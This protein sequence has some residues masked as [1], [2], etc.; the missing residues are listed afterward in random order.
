LAASGSGNISFSATNATSGAI[1]GIITVTPNDNGDSKQFTIT[2]NPQ[3][4]PAVEI[5][6]NPGFN[7]CESVGSITFTA[8][9]TNEGASP[10]YEWKVDG[11]SV[12]T[13]A[14]EN[15]TLNNLNL[16]RKSKISCTLTTS[17]ACPTTTTVSQEKNIQISSCVI[18]VNPHIRGKIR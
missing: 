17:I 18:P 15:Y 5:S 6:A 4:T 16:Y 12:Q 10:S 14:S 9:P 11:I 1:S 8:T 7:V 2:V 13:G 3:L